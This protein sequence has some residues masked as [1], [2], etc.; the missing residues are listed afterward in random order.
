MM[1]REKERIQIAMIRD[2]DP[3]A[4]TIVMHANRLTEETIK[5]VATSYYQAC[6]FYYEPT[7]FAWRNKIK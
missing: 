6:Q 3:Q 4:R 2:P 7:F 1:N 5:K